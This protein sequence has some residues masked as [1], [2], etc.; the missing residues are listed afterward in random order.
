MSGL[1]GKRPQFHEDQAAIP[2]AAFFFL[3]GEWG[4]VVCGC[5][6]VFFFQMLLCFF[7]I[8]FLTFSFLS[9]AFVVFC[10]LFC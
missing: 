7:F 3:G 6:V 4:F 5:F 1:W 10:Y 8:F 9:I 2:A